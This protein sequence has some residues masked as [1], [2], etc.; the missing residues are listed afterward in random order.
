MKR[1]GLDYVDLLF[2]HRPDYSTPMEET[3][4]AFDWLIRKGYVFYWG[5][6]EWEAADIA[7]AHMVCEKYNLVKPVMEQCEYNLY[8]RKKME[9]DYKRLFEDNKLGTTVWSPL[10]SGILTGKYNDGAVVEDSRFKNNPDLLRIFNARFTDKKEET[11]KSLN[12]F[13]ALADELNCTMAQLAMAWVINNPDISTAI[14]GA[15]SPKQ[16]EDTFQA[17]TVR[18]KLTPEIEKRIELLFN[19][20]PKGKLDIFKGGPGKSRR[21]LK[22][23]VNLDE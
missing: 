6:S 13:K 11:L 20:A 9:I 15:S 22:L 3:C 21:L 12:G 19:T 23:G 7:E 8:N 5:T 10:A 18:K 1:L 16:L 14:T 2:C 17:V 4:R